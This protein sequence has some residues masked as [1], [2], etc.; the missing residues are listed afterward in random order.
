MRELFDLNLDSPTG[1]LGSLRLAVPVAIL[2]FLVAA[3]ATD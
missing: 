2:L 1:R 3:L